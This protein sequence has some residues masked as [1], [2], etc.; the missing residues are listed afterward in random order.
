[1]LTNL[2]SWGLTV[3]WEGIHTVHLSLLTTNPLFPIRSPLEAQYTVLEV[4]ND[5]SFE[6]HPTHSKQ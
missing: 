3:L 4:L 5:D 2:R 1:M 6:D